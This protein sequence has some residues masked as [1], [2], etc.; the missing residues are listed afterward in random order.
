[1][2]ECLLFFAKYFQIHSVCLELFLK[3]FAIK[4]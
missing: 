1:M 2:C 4:V 3:M